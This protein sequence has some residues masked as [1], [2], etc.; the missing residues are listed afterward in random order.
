MLSTD[1]MHVEINCF[2]FSSLSLSPSSYVCPSIFFVIA[3]KK[4]RRKKTLFAYYFFVKIVLKAKCKCPD[5]IYAMHIC[6]GLVCESS[7]PVC[8]L[9]KTEETDDKTKKKIRKTL[10]PTKKKESWKA[11]TLLLK[12]TIFEHGNSNKLRMIMNIKFEE[13]FTTAL[14]TIILCL[15]MITAWNSRLCR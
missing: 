12:T 5:E 2:S 8:D 15:S 11:E 9:L 1:Y 3:S 4:K 6:V 7:M 13:S 14:K 10:V